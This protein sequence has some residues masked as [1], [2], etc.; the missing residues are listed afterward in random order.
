MEVANND[1]RISFPINLNL[2]IALKVLKVKAPTVK[3]NG[4]VFV[5]LFNSPLLKVFPNIG[6]DP[7]KKTLV[8][9]QIIEK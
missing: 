8:G 9:S 7:I 4:T 3:S 2:N 6:Q 5:S 1:E